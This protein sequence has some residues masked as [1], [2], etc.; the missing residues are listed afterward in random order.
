MEKLI[1][2]NHCPNLRKILQ[3]ETVNIFKSTNEYYQ[4]ISEKS[5]LKMALYLAMRIVFGD[6][7]LITDLTVNLYATN[8][9][10]IT[11]IKQ[12]KCSPHTHVVKTL[13]MSSAVEAT[14]GWMEVIE[15]VYIDN[16]GPVHIE[17]N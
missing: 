7:N 10:N 17:R 13:A 16:E 5:S 6:K 15:P 14:S 8:F 4:N 12:I 2:G 11:K 3:L 1:P 9:P